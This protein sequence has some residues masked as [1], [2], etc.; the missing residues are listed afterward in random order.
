MQHKQMLPPGFIKGRSV[1]KIF[2]NSYCKLQ[3]LTGAHT[4]HHTIGT[5]FQSRPPSDDAVATA[6]HKQ[7]DVSNN[8]D[9]VKTDYGSF[10]IPKQKTP[11]PSFPEFK[12]EYKDS[13]V[14][15]EAMEHSIAWVLLGAVGDDCLEEQY[16]QV[17]RDELGPV[18]SW[19][20]FMK[21]VTN[22]S[23]TKCKLEYLAVVPLPPGDNV[24][25]WY[26]DMIVQMADDLELDYLCTRR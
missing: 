25:K 22:C 13:A 19:T 2:S 6:A 1:H 9:N 10:K 4:T 21:S 15:S 7:S 23:T 8:M 26:M 14:L 11:L 3:T 16:P 12:D 20:S 17:D 18:G 5:I 24:I